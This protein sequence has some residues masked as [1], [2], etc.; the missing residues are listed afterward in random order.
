MNRDVLVTLPRLLL[1]LVSVSGS[2]YGNPKQPHNGL[3]RRGIESKVEVYGCRRCLGMIAVDLR[4]RGKPAAGA[5]VATRRS[6][7]MIV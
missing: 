1:L 4:A 3:R 7:A 6:H 5:F 2:E